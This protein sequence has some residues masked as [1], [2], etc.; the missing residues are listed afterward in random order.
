MA[1]VPRSELV[2][3]LGVAA[4]R[5]VHIER[6]AGRRDDVVLEGVTRRKELGAFGHAVEI[7]FVTGLD[8]IETA[9]QA[10]G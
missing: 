5:D 7:G 3:H 10:L 6:I 8:R 1:D 9:R 4:V 2:H